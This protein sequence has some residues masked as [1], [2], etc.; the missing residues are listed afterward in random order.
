MERGRRAGVRER[1]AEGGSEQQ[2]EGES[3]QERRS[4]G[5][6]TARLIGES[7]SEIWWD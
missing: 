6:L 7:A 2:R 1:E 3:S 5:G 4:A